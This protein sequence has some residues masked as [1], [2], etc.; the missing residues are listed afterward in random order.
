MKRALISPNQ[1]AF[2]LVDN[3]RQGSELGAFVVQIED[4]ANEFAVGAPFYWVDCPDDTVA[5]RNYYNK[6]KRTFGVCPAPV[7]TPLTPEQKLAKTGL[8]VDELKVLLGL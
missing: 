5:Y 4:A 8:T 3:V 7:V 6:S 1:P 2:A